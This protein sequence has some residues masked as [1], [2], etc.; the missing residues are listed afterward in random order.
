MGKEQLVTHRSTQA[1]KRHGWS[2]GK[3]RW[4]EEK[5]GRDANRLGYNCNEQRK[6]WGTSGFMRRMVRAHK[7]RREDGWGMNRM[8]RGTFNSG[9]E[10]LVQRWSKELNG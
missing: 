7:N 6:D 3:C 9:E 5:S 2:T 8:R 1:E 4:I 10:L